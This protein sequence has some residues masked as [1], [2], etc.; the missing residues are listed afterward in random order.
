MG[1]GLCPLPLGRR[2]SLFSGGD[3][4]LIL[5]PGD[6]L[7]P[8][9]DPFL[10]GKE[11]G[12]RPLTAPPPPLTLS[13]GRSGGHSRFVLQ[14]MEDKQGET[15]GLVGSGAGAALRAC[16]PGS[17]LRPRTRLCPLGFH[18]S[19]PLPAALRRRTSPPRGPRGQ[20]PARPFSG[21]LRAAVR[22]VSPGVACIR[23]P[24]AAGCVGCE[25]GPGLP[26]PRC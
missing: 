24:C 22:D 19:V 1:S 16:A 6:I 8:L 7:C 3:S 2:L 14:V 23:G 17:C 4:L 25:G 13:W 21:S 18:S 5:G 12:S 11:E 15:G 10:C 26:R 20:A 9:R